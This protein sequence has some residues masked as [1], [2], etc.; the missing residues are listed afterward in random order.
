MARLAPVPNKYQGEVKHRRRFALTQ[1]LLAEV[2]RARDAGENCQL[3]L[4]N[5]RGTFIRVR[6]REAA[7]YVQSR[8][9]NGLKK[10]KLALISEIR[11]SEV[12][13][14]A[15]AVIKTIKKALD[16][17]VVID[18]WKRGQ[19]EKETEVALDN[20]E[21]TTMGF[22]TFGETIDQYIARTET[23]DGVTKNRLSPPS[24]REIK[25]RL[26]DKVEAAPLMARSVKE[27]RYDDIEDVRD[28]I[29]ASGGGASSGAK[30]IDLS[31]RVLSWAAKFRRRKTGLDP[32]YPW[33]N[34]LAHEYKPSD[35]SQRYLTPMQ[36]GMLIALLEGVRVLE[37]RT[38][39]AVLG[40]IQLG[41]M[42]VQRSAALVSME[43]LS[44]DRWKD[45]PVDD[46]AGWRVFTWIADSVKGKRETK[47]SIPPAAIAVIER[48]AA[49]ARV[50][51]HIDSQWAFPQARNKYLLRA[52][53]K[54]KNSD[55][56][57][58]FD[59]HVTSSAL[60]HALDS[61]AGRKAGWPNLLQ[62]VGLPERIGPHD[63]RRS[64]T[65]FFENR[66][67]GSYA[68]ALLD[69]KVIGTDKMSEQV[70]AVT[71]GVYSGADRVIFKAEAL[72]IW[73]NAVL[74]YYEMAKA[75]PRLKAAIE[76][77]RA[78]L[79]KN[80]MTGIEKRAATLVAKRIESGSK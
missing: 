14:L 71:Q 64:L 13:S 45:D 9:P 1:G 50:L 53:A 59:K 78:S 56:I 32:T 4:D 25:D 22:W 75:D 27:L 29:D 7:Y 17:D 15:E 70:A 63:L 31:K 48:V 33:W 36:A 76:T 61:L 44:S 42:I 3:A 11:I 39:D 74:P 62:M 73:L 2:R 12:K 5:P 66:G 58:R 28:K 16:P 79:E 52:Y 23:K 43:S 26:R 77:R 55:G 65:T 51:T 60:N 6:A 8:G 30:F 57:C 38:N 49:N 40:A 72:E 54:S 18:A 35:R 34:A 69:H 41:W 20:A 24:L 21:A 68:S 10:R 80:K 19:N 67:Q 46:R 47:L 37:D